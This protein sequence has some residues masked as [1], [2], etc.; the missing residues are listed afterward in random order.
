MAG[1][2]GIPRHPL[3]FDTLFKLPLAH[4]C[5]CRPYADSASNKSLANCLAEEAVIN[6]LAGQGKLPF[7]K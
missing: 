4:R 2:S 1:G 6:K 7:N 3:D 5:T